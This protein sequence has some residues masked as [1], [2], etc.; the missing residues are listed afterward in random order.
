MYEIFV[1]TGSIITETI[2]S[3]GYPG[4]LFFMTLESAAI[5][6]PSEIIMPFSGYLVFGGEFR[7][8]WVV[9]WGSVGNLL[10]SIILYAVGFY[11]GRRF[12]EKYGRWVLVSYYDLEMADR[13]FSK[14]G[15]IIIFVSR[16][17]PAVRTYISFPAGVARMDFKKFALYTF[18]G[19]VPWTYVLAYFGIILG[20]N[21]TML[22][23]YFRKL[24]IA[25][26]L[27]I[28]IIAI[29]WVRRHLNL[30]RREKTR[31]IV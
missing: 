4:I 28:L 31:Q 8:L 1:F 22:E 2:S 11:G 9:F 5:P 20:E 24:D 17:L 15:Q 13:L 18:A 7:L 30:R 6:I 26:A 16:M 19:S 10:G 3:L 27:V 14:Y 23:G 25:I 29:W 12:L 21:W